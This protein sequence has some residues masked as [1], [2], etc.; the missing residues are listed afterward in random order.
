MGEDDDKTE[1]SPTSRNRENDDPIT[2]EEAS[3]GSDLDS[4]SDVDSAAHMSTD[5]ESE[6]EDGDFEAQA[7]TMLE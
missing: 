5:A 7:R 1:V 6:I 2:W 4:D 3:K